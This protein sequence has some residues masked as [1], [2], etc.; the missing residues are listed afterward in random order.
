M[1][2][3]L[4]RA[5]RK[6]LTVVSVG[7]ALA[8]TVVVACGLV[9]PSGAGAA[10]PATPPWQSPPP[11]LQLGGLLFFGSTGTQITSGSI[12]AQPFAAYVEGTSVLNASNAEATV[13]AY[14]PGTKPG[15]SPALWS[16]TALGGTTTYPNPAAPAPIKTSKFPVYTGANTDLSIKSYT[17][18]FPNENPTPAYTGIYE[19][20][21]KTMSPATT[22]YDATDI[23]VTGTTWSVVYPTSVTTIMAS[24]TSPQHAGTKV[25]FTATITPSTATGTVQF[26]TGSTDIGSP[27]AVTAGT[28]SITTSTLPLG[29]DLVSATFSPT[30]D[31]AYSSSIGNTVFSVT[32]APT[33][34]TLTTT[35]PDSQAV[36]QNVKLEASLTPTT[37][38]GTVQFKVGTTDIGSPVTVSGG[39]ASTTT[40]ALPIGTDDLSAVY[41]PTSGSGYGPSMG[42]GSIKIT[43]IPT[44]T[45][46]TVTPASPRDYGTSV[47]LKATV[48]PSGAP[49]TVKFTVGS[50]TLGTKAVSAG[51]ASITTTAL[52]IGTNTVVATFTPTAD[53]G[54]GPSAGTTSYT[55]TATPTT[56]TLTATPAG[57]STYGSTVSLKATVS[58]S[59]AP[60]TVKFTVGSTTLGTKAVSA[61]IASITTTALPIGTNTVVATFTSTADSGYGP[62]MGTVSYTIT[63][64]TTTTTLTATPASPQ[65]VG[66]S[67]T[68]KATVTPS[69]AP[70]TVKFTVGPTTL[71]TKAV[72]GGVASITTTALPVGADTIT[73]AFTPSSGNYAGSTGTASFTVNPVTVT[74]TTLT[75]TPASPQYVGTVVTLKATVAPTTAPG[76]VQFKVGSTVLGTKTVSG[77]TASITTAALPVGAVTIV[78]TFTPTPDKGYGPSTGTLSFTVVPLT[79]TTTTLTATPASPQTYGTAVT[80]K[81]SVIPDA[82]PGAV[83]FEVGSTA[84]GGPVAVSGGTASVTTSTLPVG[85]DPLSAV[86][87]PTADSGYG[88]STGTSSFT[89][90]P[91][92]TTTTLS[93]TPASPQTYG[94]AVTLKASVSPSAAPGSVQFEVGSTDIGGPIAVSDG[95]ASVTTSSLPAGTDSL[96]AVFAP[97]A[98]SGYGGSTGTTSFT[99]T[100]RSGKGYWEVA[101]DGGIFAYGTA[102]FY[103]SMGGQPLNQPIVGI[104]ATVDGKG[105][106]EV[107]ADGGIFAFGDARFYGS[108]GGQPL[109]KPIVGIAV[110]PDGQGYWEVASD[111]GI[112]AFGDARF[113][114][115]M[116]GQPLNRPIVGIA[117]TPDGQGYW[118]VASDGGIF[119]FGDAAFYGS[120]GSLTLAQPIVGVAPTPDGGGYW[121][122]AADGGLFAFGDAG[123]HG[124]VPAASVHVSNVVGIAATPDGAGYWLVGSDGGIYA[125]GDAPFYGSAGSLTLVQPVVGMAEA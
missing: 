124:S 67:V 116:G 42:T 98:G 92:S 100:G 62:S 22:A 71:G 34:T 107:A 6:A 123:Y 111:G 91:I 10:P 110:T 31:D 19:I 23:K 103:G 99:V 93:V 66:T 35:P 114:G 82:A 96:S 37:A 30:V 7:A 74:T 88:G 56:T 12:T 58:P 75:A 48:A 5:A 101:A 102:P 59:G 105:Y 90:N 27:V 16:G 17:E 40:T 55:I 61:G 109:N 9:A 53:S 80:L 112:F 125:F 106:W 50:T 41:T 95:T 28:A 3:H 108:M 63:K 85:S 20:R 77:G 54:Y 8:G 118:E 25:T 57:T 38:P 78:A 36:G 32:T 1:N 11:A 94:T 73:A 49:G 26:K 117:V 84:I 86:F 18:G 44:T 43:A 83:Q 115:S 46:L 69:G 113:Y 121:L 70:G 81:A 14:T 39:Q 21:L 29:T 65:Y 119:A 64:I 24:P 13:Y 60:G 76:S 97:S 89:V 52:P 79:S 15:E 33:K 45:I 68:L 87:T 120:T 4:R 122:A 51:I 104:A 72:S 2:L 47:N